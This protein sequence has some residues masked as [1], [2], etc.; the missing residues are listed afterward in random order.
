[1]HFVLGTTYPAP[2]K[3]LARFLLITFSLAVRVGKLQL[4]LLIR[5]L[6]QDLPDNPNPRH[7][8]AVGVLE[9][10]SRR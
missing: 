10:F 1:M 2:L 4:N 3:L 9:G 7:G 6:L 8:I 5:D